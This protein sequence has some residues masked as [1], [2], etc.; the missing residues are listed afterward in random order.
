LLFE[1]VVN[2]YFVLVSNLL[3]DFGMV[4]DFVIVKVSDKRAGKVR[5]IGTA[6]NPG[7]L[8]CTEPHL[9]LP[10]VRRQATVG[11]TAIALQVLQ[12]IFPTLSG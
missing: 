3:E 1:P 6:S 2:S 5:T 7:F 4:T 10:A 11:Q 9:T 8:L 12:G